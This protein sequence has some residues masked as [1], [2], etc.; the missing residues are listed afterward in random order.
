MDCESID[1]AV[2]VVEPDYAICHLE[3]LDENSARLLPIQWTICGVF[4]DTIVGVLTTTLGPAMLVSAQLTTCIP[5][6]IAIQNRV[7]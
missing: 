1:R 7:E 4:I 3:L 5:H 6:T 2:E